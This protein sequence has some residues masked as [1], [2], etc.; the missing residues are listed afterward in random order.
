MKITFC[1]KDFFLYMLPI[2]VE[3]EN[4][5]IGRSPLMSDSQIKNQKLAK[6]IISLMR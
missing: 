5:S 3:S 1:I 6:K 4:I 2:I